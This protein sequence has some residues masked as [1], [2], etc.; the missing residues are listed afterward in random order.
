M[1]DFFLD[2]RNRECRKSSRAASMLKFY[3]DISV[4]SFEN[5]SF[6]LVVTCADN[7]ELWG[8][9]ESPDG[10]QIVALA[11]RLAFDSKDWDAA[12]VICG[13]GGLA[14]KAV[15]R[16]YQKQGSKALET[17]NGN[18][19]LVLH[20]RT[21][22]TCFI[23]IDRCG[24]FPCFEI[25]ASGNPIAICSHPDTLAALCD[26][27]MDWDETSLAEFI[28]AGKISYPYTYY[29]KI[30]ALEFGSIHTIDLSGEAPHYRSKKKCFPFEYK[31]DPQCTEWDI[32]EQLG[33][34]FRKA[35]TRRTLPL[36]GKTWMSLSGG[37]DTRA[38]LC[39]TEPAEHITT[40]SCYDEENLEFRI[41]KAIAKQRGVPII[42]LK[43]N[44]EHYGDNA[45][46]GVRISGGMDS[47]FNNHFLGFRSEFKKYGV[48]NLILGFFCDYLFKSLA[49]D[50]QLN[51]WTQIESLCPFKHEYYRP[52]YWQETALG[53]RVRERM[54]SI[55]T[56]DMRNDKSVIGPLR[57]Q[58]KRLFPLCYDAD[59]AASVIPERIM[60]WYLPTVDNDIMNVY[61]TVPPEFKIN[62]SMYSKM[63]Q[64][65]CGK[66]I[67]RITNINTGAPVNAPYAR[68]LFQRYLS[69]LHHRFE[70]LYKPSIALSGSW[71]NWEYYTSHSKVLA[72][73]WNRK[74]PPAM[75]F[76]TR[77]FGAN[78]FDR[79]PSDY[80][81]REVDLFSRLVTLKIWMG[82]R[83]STER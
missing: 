17:L 6:S 70:K 35:V 75:E 63:V 2:F 13:P 24:M 36:F 15:Y 3:D 54:D 60:P 80:R 74:N 59:N 83:I 73:L 7:P 16:A 29:N 8:S 49:I 38:I 62:V 65:Q 34:A 31:I 55:F 81:P 64:K 46:M 51:K 20:D 22:Q 32:A 58:E 45:E 4:A 44:F 68:I 25:E 23:V 57:I 18:Y 53:N 30:R 37:L 72:D 47:I 26:V 61:L 71:P 10:K 52:I 19:V 11:G 50:H 48:E 21:L 82:Q 41:A 1:G 14:C 5:D 66:Q 27:S 69:A 28:V 67:S 77:L 43:R 12:R 56:E 76:A 39:S 42:P 78:P 33:L 40:F 79:A 9:Y